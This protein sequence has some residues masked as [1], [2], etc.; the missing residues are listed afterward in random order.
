MYTKNVCPYCDRAKALLQSKG[1][2]WEEINIESVDGALDEMI[3]RSRQRT[4]P[5]IWI[6]DVHVGGS[7]DLFA[8]DAEGKLDPLLGVRRAGGGPA[9]ETKVAIVGSGPAGY[10]AAIYAARA[11][12]EPVVL[13]GAAFGGQLMLTTDVENYPGFPEGITGPEMMELFQKQ[14]E[15]F[16]TRVFNE[17]ATRI[18]FDSRPF[19]IHTDSREVVADSLIV[20]TGASARWLGL[21]SEERLQNRG[22]SACATCDGALFRDKPMAVVGGGD[23]AIEEALF[24]TRFATRVNLIH[25]RDELRASKIMAERAERSE[26]IEFV[27]DSV[28]EEVLGDDHVTGVRVRNL[29]TE[30]LSDID[31]EAL[32]IA[33]GHTPNTEVLAGRIDLNDAGYVVTKQGSTYTNVAGVFACGDVMDPTYRQAVTAA[34][35]GCMA[36]LDAERWLAARE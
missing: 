8:L 2:Q 19:R 23:T 5:Q 10:T 33:I 16:G 32:F 6:D 20:A 4:V 9:I 21:D 26:K 11:E 25:R 30:G 14:A 36:A 1:V 22:V 12:L 34:G 18:D 28:V 31:V 17:D 13:A 35:S 15:R 7:D 3:E 29:K 27:W 24:L